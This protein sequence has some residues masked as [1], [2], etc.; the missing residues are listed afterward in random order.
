[1]DIAQLLGQWLP[2]Q[3]QQG[4]HSWLPGFNE[5][6][7]TVTKE[8]I[9]YVAPLLKPDDRAAVIRSVL[10]ASE[11]K[12]QLPPE[13][14]TTTDPFERADSSLDLL[15]N[16]EAGLQTACESQLLLPALAAR[17]G[18][19]IRRLRFYREQLQDISS[20]QAG[21][22]MAFKFVEG[23]VIEAAQQGHWILLD[24]INS[25]PPEIVERLNSLLEETPSLNL[26]EHG[27]G[28]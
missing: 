2:A 23:P 22:G 9:V 10:F 19:L 24:N 21:H 6:I 1:M 27:S 20:M 26:Y 18:K 12:H 8:L 16:L 7:A 3:D 5:Y 11:A 15:E 25:A 4:H 28:M 14:E 13:S 17:V